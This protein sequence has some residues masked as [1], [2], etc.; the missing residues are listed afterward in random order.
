MCQAGDG[1][2][3]HQ[4]RWHRLAHG[5]GR[6]AREQRRHGSNRQ[7]PVVLRNPTHGSLARP[8]ALVGNWWQ[9]GARPSTQ[10]RSQAHGRAPVSPL[11]RGGT[12]A[13]CGGWI[14]GL[15]DFG[16]LGGGK[17]TDFRMLANNRLVRGEVDA[18]GFVVGNVAFEPLDAGGKLVQHLVGLGGGTAQLLP[19]KGSNLRDVALNDELAQSHDRFS[20]TKLLICRLTLPPARGR[21]PPARRARTIGAWQTSKGAA[22]PVPAVPGPG[23][24]G[25]CA[26]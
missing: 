20:S 10:P 8:P 4:R 9:A 23:M 6:T 13:G 15:L 19:L 26:D 17:A 22:D 21:S 5:L 1:G 3:R 12:S 24:Q 14:D 18:E 7:G 11:D 25:P 16:D 2:F